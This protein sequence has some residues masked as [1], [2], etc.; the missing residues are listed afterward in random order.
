MATYDANGMP[1]KH[2]ALWYRLHAI[3]EMTHDQKDDMLA[4]LA[5]YTESGWDMAYEKATGNWQVPLV[6][7]DPDYHD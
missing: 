3:E 7:D 6:E 2:T 1:E 5:G 4:F